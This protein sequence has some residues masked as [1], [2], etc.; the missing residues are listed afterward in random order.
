MKRPTGLVKVLAS[1][2]LRRRADEII[3]EAERTSSRNARERLRDAAARIL[4]AASYER[5]EAGLG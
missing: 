2:R 5:M 1:E 3:N 4:E